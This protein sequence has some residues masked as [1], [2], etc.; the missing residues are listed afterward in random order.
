MTNILVTHIS[1]D[2]DAFTSCW[3][4]KKYLP[5]WDNAIIKYVSAGSTLNNK[6]PDTDKHIIHTDTGFGKFDHHQ[7]NA[8]TSASKLLYEFLIG[9]DYIPT[10]Y[11]VPLRRMV[12]F[13]N[14]IDHF[15]EVNFPDPADDRY[16]FLL[17][18][19]LEGLKHIIDIQTEGVDI[20]FKLLD[21]TLYLF[22]N[23]V[24]A[25]EEIKKG[26]VFNSRWGKSLAMEIRNE[27]AMKL[28]MK[29]GYNL[30]LCK[31]PKN[32]GIRIKTVPGKELSLE[33]V[34]KEILKKDKK[35]TWFLHASN[36][37]LLNAT[38]KNPQLIPTLLTLK[39]MIDII[40]EM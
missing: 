6:P 22:H 40:K 33:P 4:I 3:L 26:Y 32:G 10:K 29:T 11:I 8:Y 13:V 19:T 15:A 14:H 27:E 37:M 28:A 36:N 17:S 16:Y 20:V 7:T 31:D 23:K 2:L 35:G 39:Q 5:G 38:S 34:Y 18:E 24:R 9:K 1:P 30:V 21:A 25:E 12:E